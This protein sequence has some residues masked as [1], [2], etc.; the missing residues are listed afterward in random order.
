M[1]GMGVPVK[2]QAL[3][4]TKA[5]IPMFNPAYQQLA[6]AQQQPAYVPVSCKCYYVFSG[7]TT[8]MYITQ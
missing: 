1:P 8:N 6:Y 4:A 3:D 2:R 5:G 7:S